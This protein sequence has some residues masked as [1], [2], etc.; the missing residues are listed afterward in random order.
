M[1]I[2]RRM[3]ENSGY[4]MDYYYPE[5]Q[6]IEL[7]RHESTWKSLRKLTLSEKHKLHS[8]TGQW[9]RTDANVFL[10]MYRRK[11]S[12]SGEWIPTDKR[13]HR[14]H[15]ELQPEDFFLESDLK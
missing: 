13:D 1:F 3:D 8:V 10:K 5:L 7:G 4:T 2:K 15:N 11:T 6:F 14:A 12:N 9:T